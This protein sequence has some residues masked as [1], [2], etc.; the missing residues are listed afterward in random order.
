V[1]P[2]ETVSTAGNAVESHAQDQHM[3]SLGMVCWSLQV[4]E[5]GPDDVGAIWASLHFHCI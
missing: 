2:S 3:M 5:D 1:T 4:G